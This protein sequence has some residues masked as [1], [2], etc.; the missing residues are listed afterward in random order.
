MSAAQDQVLISIHEFLVR[1]RIEQPVL[2]RWVAAGWIIPRREPELAF[3][4]VDVARATLIRELRDDFGVNDEGVDLILHLID[5]VHGLRRSL[6]E[7]AEEIRRT[8]ERSG[9]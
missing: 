5:Q 1:V 9:S 7:L 8:R 4:E 3:S 6:R 2:E